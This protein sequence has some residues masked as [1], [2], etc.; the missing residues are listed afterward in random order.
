VFDRF[1]RDEQARVVKTKGAGLGLSI[2][3]WIVQKHQGTIHIISRQDIGTKVSMTLP[4]L[5][6]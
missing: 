2:A 4:L 5:N 3:K 6:R 1:Y